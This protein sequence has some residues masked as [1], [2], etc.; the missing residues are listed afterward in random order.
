MM[1]GLRLLK[2]RCGAEIITVCDHNSAQ[3]S[4]N[5]APNHVIR[6]CLKLLLLRILICAHPCPRRALQAKRMRL[7]EE[8]SGRFPV[9]VYL[10][11]MV[12]QQ[13]GELQN[14]LP[15]STLVPRNLGTSCSETIQSRFV[16]QN[17][18]IE[19]L[20]VTVMQKPYSIEILS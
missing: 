4:I 11:P 2:A 13:V 6:C 12:I 20:G 3:D 5:H 1:F 10:M 16:E 17:I 15:N 14:P 7:R 19:D 18:S 8:C 9:L